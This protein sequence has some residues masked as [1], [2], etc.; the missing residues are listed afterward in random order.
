M[1]K[2]QNALWRVR[3]G[4]RLQNADSCV[5]KE[6]GL[7][8]E[9]TECRLCT[10]SGC[11]L[12]AVLITSDYGSQVAQRKL[13]RTRTRKRK[14]NFMWPTFCLLSTLPSLI[15]QNEQQLPVAPTQLLKSLKC[16]MK[17]ITSF[18]QST[19]SCKIL[20]V[21]SYTTSMGIYTR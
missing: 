4:T 3:S 19:D 11:M 8:G 13:T 10:Q 20:P 14:C 2:Q 12:N 1:Y 7:D 9:A 6:L 15:L 17:I 18:R 5:S 21:S 16:K